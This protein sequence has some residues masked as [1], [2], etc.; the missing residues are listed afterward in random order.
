MVMLSRSKV[1]A[2]RSKKIRWKTKKNNC[3]ERHIDG[4]QEMLFEIGNDAEQIIA[5]IR[6]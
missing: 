4:D 1:R 6:R 2:V 5:F 3:G